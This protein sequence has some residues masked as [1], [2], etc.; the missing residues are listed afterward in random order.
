MEKWERLH[1]ANQFTN[2]RV[3]R[4]NSNDDRV[5]VLWK[6]KANYKRR[7]GEV[8]KDEQNH[9]QFVANNQ[10]PEART[11]LILRETQKRFNKR[12]K[13]QQACS[14]D[15]T[16]WEKINQKQQHTPYYSKSNTA[17]RLKPRAFKLK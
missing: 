14:A 16:T 11:N 2:I 12:G 6:N 17:K 8:G 10:Q 9:G 4:R 13:Q 5:R 3:G 7:I 1:F 15:Q